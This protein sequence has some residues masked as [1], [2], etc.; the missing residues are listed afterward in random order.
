MSLPLGDF[1][2]PAVTQSA[3]QL[4]DY[5]S[6]VGQVASDL[7]T[8]IEQ[9]MP[10]SDLAL[11]QVPILDD[12]HRPFVLAEVKDRRFRDQHGLGQPSVVM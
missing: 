12:P 7:I 5:I 10:E 11:L 2:G 9:T 3:A 4:R 6:A 8:S 1:G